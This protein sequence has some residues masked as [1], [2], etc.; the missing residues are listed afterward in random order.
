MNRIL[1]NNLNINI[2]AEYSVPEG[3]ELG[4]LVNHPHLNPGFELQVPMNQFAPS[5][6]SRGSLNSSLLDLSNDNQL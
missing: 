5:N 3:V 6:S 1:E 2:E 4:N